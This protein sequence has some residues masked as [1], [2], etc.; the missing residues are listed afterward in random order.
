[1][2]GDLDVNFGVSFPHWGNLKPGVLLGVVLCQP[3]R[4]AMWSERSP[5]SYP[6]DVAF[7]SSVVREGALPSSLCL[8]IFTMV[9]CLSIVVSCFSYKVD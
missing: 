4:G 3:G 9:S 7:L 8:G 5:S 6:P 2:L 1:M